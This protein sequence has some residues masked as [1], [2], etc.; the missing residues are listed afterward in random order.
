[1]QCL[2]V[3]D[4]IVSYSNQ[5]QW[6]CINK[7]QRPL[8]SHYVYCTARTSTAALTQQLF[9]IMLL[10]SPNLC[11]KHSDDAITLCTAHCQRSVIPDTGLLHVTTVI[12]L[13]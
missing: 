13:L 10:M 3:Q 7:V 4:T 1:M 2:A 12:T 8:L 9:I 5:Q 11:S 6:I